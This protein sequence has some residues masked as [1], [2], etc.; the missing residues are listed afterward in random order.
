MATPQEFAQ[1]HMALAQRVGQRLGVDPNALLAQWGL[2]TGWG[3]SILPGTHNLGNITDPTGR[4]VTAR[5]VGEGRNLNFARYQSFDDFGDKYAGLLERRYKS[6]LNTGSDIGAF[7]T[8]LKAGGYA[9]DPNYV[10]NLVSTYNRLTGSSAQAPAAAPAQPQAAPQF[11]IGGITGATPNAAMGRVPR[12]Q[13]ADPFDLGRIALGVGGNS[14]PRQQRQSYNLWNPFNL[15]SV[16][17]RPIG[18]YQWDEAA[19]R[20]L[21]RNAG[22]R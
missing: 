4:G 9:S 17:S 16:A 5:D 1:Q 7:A 2:E 14:P 20:Q 12:A 19:L 11:P 15:P 13:E 3:R 10:R 21:M 8:G 18:P 22:I 6:A